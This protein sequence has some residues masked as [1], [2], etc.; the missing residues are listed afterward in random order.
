MTARRNIT[1]IDDLDESE[2]EFFYKM[3]LF[4][5]IFSIVCSW[6]AW[7]SVFIHYHLIRVFMAT[8]AEDKK[9][10][11][12]I[13]FLILEMF[14]LMSLFFYFLLI[15]AQSIKFLEQYPALASVYRVV[16]TMI[17]VV[18]G[19]L[20]VQRVAVFYDI[21]HTY[22]GKF[23][24]IC[25]IITLISMIFFAVLT[26][27]VTSSRSKAEK[28]DIESDVAAMVE[29]ESLGLPISIML[30]NKQKR[31]MLLNRIFRRFHC[32]KGMTGVAPTNMVPII[33]G[34]A[35]ISSRPEPSNGISIRTTA[36]SDF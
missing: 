13:G 25:P 21:F 32:F 18:E 34:N 11:Y 9:N 4:Y 7:V 31:K 30:G 16:P 6:V 12:F 28:P 24:T 20:C 36:D 10:S 22:V 2:R 3:Q 5:I 19:F 15:P 26:T 29:L 17:T 23:R 8:Y 27:F 14:S 35:Y 1:S 33:N